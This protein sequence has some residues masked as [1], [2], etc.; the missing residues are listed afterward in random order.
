MTKQQQIDALQKQLDAANEQ[1]A[2]IDNALKEQYVN[3]ATNIVSEIKD[4]FEDQSEHKIIL[5]YKD[6]YN[7]LDS[8]NTT[9][10]ATAP[11]YKPSILCQLSTALSETC[12]QVAEQRIVITRQTETIKS[13]IVH[14]TKD[15][16]NRIYGGR[17]EYSPAD[18]Y[19]QAVVS[20]YLKQLREENNNESE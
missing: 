7:Y 10:E 20:E 6:I 19:G 9:I 11:K 15:A 18:L 13:L 12:R 5:C 1:I 14:K 4:W 16:L 17:R 8:L 2:T 3:I